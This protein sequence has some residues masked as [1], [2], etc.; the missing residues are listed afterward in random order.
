MDSVRRVLDLAWQCGAGGAL[1]YHIVTGWPLDW[2]VGVAVWGIA[3]CGLR[4]WNIP[5]TDRR[6]VLDLAVVAI[7]SMVL[8]T[9]AL[10]LAA[11]NMVP[12][13][14]ALLAASMSC[15]RL[16]AP[17]AVNGAQAVRR[18]SVRH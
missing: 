3:V 17:Y 1:L 18:I 5:G 6:A 2:M 9:A 15:S 14:P 10:V 7:P 11:A 12:L 13:T 8:V 16:A 4:L